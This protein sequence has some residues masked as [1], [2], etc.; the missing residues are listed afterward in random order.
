M[1]L[2]LG[3][4]ALLALGA[5][6]LLAKKKGPVHHHGSDNDKLIIEEKRA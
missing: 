5:A 4:L 3:A 6:A 1:L 2:G